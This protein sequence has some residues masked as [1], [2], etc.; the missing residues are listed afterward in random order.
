MFGIRGGWQN[1]RRRVSGRYND[2]NITGEYEVVQI[3]HIDQTF[4]AVHRLA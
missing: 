3:T 4:T 1:A 2:E